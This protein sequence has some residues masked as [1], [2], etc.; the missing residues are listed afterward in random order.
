[1]TSTT[2]PVTYEQRLQEAVEYLAVR[3]E[4]RD[5]FLSDSDLLDAAER[6]SIDWHPDAPIDCPRPDFDRMILDLYAIL[7][8]DEGPDVWT[9]P[10]VVAA[11]TEVHEAFRTAMAMFNTVCFMAGGYTE[12]V[13]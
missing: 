12:D 7:S 2:T 3:Y 11:G 4:E 10:Q 6:Y 8:P 13:S 5:N 9:P 1:M